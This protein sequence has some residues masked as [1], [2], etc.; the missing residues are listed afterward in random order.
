MDG[1]NDH[2]DP[3]DKISPLGKIGN[4]LT[5]RCGSACQRQQIT[6]AW[7][8]PGQSAWLPQTEM[9]MELQWRAKDS[10]YPRQMSKTALKWMWSDG[11]EPH[12][13]RMA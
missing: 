11:N 7:T 6:K 13:G 4:R 8:I 12:R 1:T 2:V 10:R 9:K 3:L 5:R